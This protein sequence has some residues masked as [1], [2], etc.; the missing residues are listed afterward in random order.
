[1]LFIQNTDKVWWDL[2]NILIRIWEWCVA[3]CYNCDSWNENIKYFKYE[4][5][6]KVFSYIKKECDNKM[7]IFFYGTNSI[8]HPDI[9]K[10]INDLNIKKFKKSL[11][12]SPIYNEKNLSRLKYLSIK[13]SD[14]SFDT[15]YIINS[16]EKVI[17]IIK[18]ILFVIKN[19]IKSTL[20]LF[21]DYNYYIKYFKVLFIQNKQ[22]I[23]D[24][25]INTHIWYNKCNQLTFNNNKQIILLYNCKKQI[26]NNNTITNL[27]YSYCIVKESIN[28]LDNNIEISE[29]IEFTREGNITI[30]ISWYCSKGII[31]ISNIN[32]KYID[33]IK[34]FRKLNL[35]LEKYNKWFMWQNCIKC[36]KEPYS[37]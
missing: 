11:N 32:K 36:M 28:I 3:N 12:I 34:D 37:I 14:V 31:N 4:D 1:M 33:I 27:P 16:I 23:I 20:D 15:V 17:S 10:F 29:E 21:F 30:H 8:L 6:F 7:S 2:W 9:E 22:Q 5:F 19:N 35:Y 13:Y 18:F 24:K 26:I 25:S